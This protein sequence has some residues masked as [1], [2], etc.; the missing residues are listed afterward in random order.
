MLI[1]VPVLKVASMKHLT[2]AQR[3]TIE[4]MHRQGHT[5]AEIATTIAKH[6]ST[7]SRELKR[8]ADQSNKVYTSDLAHRK[9]KQKLT[10]KRKKVYFTTA[11]RQY[12]EEKLALK[13]SPEQIVRMAKK[14]GKPCVSHERLYQ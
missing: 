4:V 14:E 13:Y 9:Y 5:E 7:V 11:I 6:K 8:N 3:Y 12:T 2:Q 10:S 1:L